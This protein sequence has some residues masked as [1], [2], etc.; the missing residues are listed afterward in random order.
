MPRPADAEIPGFDLAQ[1]APYGLTLLDE[2]F[3]PLVLE[4]GAAS[5]C[6][7]EAGA[8]LVAIVS[9][10]RPVTT[11]T[12]YLDQPAPYPAVKILP[13]GAVLAVRTRLTDLDANAALQSVRQ[14]TVDEWGPLLL[15]ARREEVMAAQALP[16][17]AA[18]LDDVATEHFTSVDDLHN[19]AFKAVRLSSSAT[20]PADSV[21]IVDG[22]LGVSVFV[23]ASRRDGSV[24]SDV[25]IFNIVGAEPDLM[26]DAVT[27]GVRCPRRLIARTRLRVAS[28]WSGVEA[29]RSARVSRPPGASM[30]KR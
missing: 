1:P 18:V 10:G 8:E 21:Q 15:D 9:R 30:R 6:V 27:R 16:V 22:D 26:I 20:N 3:D 28:A 11:F 13:D 17:D 5:G 14:A 7:A 4:E 29:A 12:M 19:A 24:L 25:W 23:N 2:T